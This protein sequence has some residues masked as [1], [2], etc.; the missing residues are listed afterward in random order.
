[1]LKPLLLASTLSIACFSSHANDNS[2]WSF[3]AGHFEHG[4][5]L[6]AKYTY[7]INEK[8]SAFASIGIIGYAFGYEYQ[9]ND[10]IDLGL[11]L[12]Q[13]AAYASDGFLV[14]K[15]NYYFSNQGKKGFY[16]GASFG[17]KEEDGEC[18]VFCAQEDT[19]K[20]KS[21]GGIHIGYRF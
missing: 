5:V 4:G 2:S 21:T 18:F 16:V 9:L 6:G 20:V 13:Q 10:H 12:G 8:H 19:E 15:A 7:E 11:T 14:A 1:M 17:V 3:G